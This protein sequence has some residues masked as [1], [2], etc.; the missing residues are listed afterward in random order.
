MI[1]ERFG[2][3]GVLNISE[4]TI[5]GMAESFIGVCFR[6]VYE[7]AAFADVDSGIKGFI[8]KGVNYFAEFIITFWAIHFALF[9]SF[10]DGGASGATRSIISSP[11]PA[12]SRSN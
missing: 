5:A 12:I 2:K 11:V 10:L 6:G 1:K 9:E 7:L 4:V 3:E 8:T